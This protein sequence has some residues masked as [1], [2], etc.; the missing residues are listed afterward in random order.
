MYF[1][2]CKLRGVH[3]AL[4]INCRPILMVQSVFRNMA[5]VARRR[6]PQNVEVGGAIPR[7]SHPV[8]ASWGNPECVIGGTGGHKA[9]S[10]DFAW[11]PNVSH[12]RVSAS[13]GISNASVSILCRIEGGSWFKARV[14]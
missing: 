1:S 6:P 9:D 4:K 11:K 3:D 14:Y 12:D 8:L 5:Y 10:T 13:V 7:L 2:I